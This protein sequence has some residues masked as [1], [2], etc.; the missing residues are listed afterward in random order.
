MEY[1]HKREKLSLLLKYASLLEFKRREYRVLLCLLP[2]LG[3]K[4]FKRIKQIDI[5]ETLGISKAEVS[6]ALK[7]LSVEILERDPNKKSMMRF[8]KYTKKRD[9]A[10]YK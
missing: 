3:F 10:A 6:K 4:N 2:D 1:K 7:V 8:R 9:F 5:I